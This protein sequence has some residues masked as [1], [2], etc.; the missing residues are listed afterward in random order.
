[1]VSEGGAFNRNFQMK[2][3]F[4]ANRNATYKPK[5]RHFCLPCVSTRKFSKCLFSEWSSCLIFK[6]FHLRFPSSLF[7]FQFHMKVVK[8]IFTLR[9]TNFS[10]NIIKFGFQRK[11]Q[12][13]L[14][15]QRIQAASANFRRENSSSLDSENSSS[16]FGAREIVNREKR[17]KGFSKC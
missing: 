2:R 10:R 1:M 12:A 15:S 11:F 8:L 4:S 16:D 17:K 13:I 7:R 5:N 14:S 9:A 6:L 3:V